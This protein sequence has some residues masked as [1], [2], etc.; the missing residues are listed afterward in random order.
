MQLFYMRD[1]IKISADI[2][3]RVGKI[4]IFDIIRFYD[5]VTEICCV[6]LLFVKVFFMP[7][8]SQDRIIAAC[9]VKCLLHHFFL[10]HLIP[11][12]DIHGNHSGCTRRK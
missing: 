6:K 3:V 5:A 12:N 9:L 4:H 1:F 10:C 8:H 11:A 7:R 2:A